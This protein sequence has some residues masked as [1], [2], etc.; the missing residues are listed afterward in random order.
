MGACYEFYLYKIVHLIFSYLKSHKISSPGYT[1]LL[2]K[3]KIITLSWCKKYLKNIK[4]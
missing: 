2:S 3:S 4:T 1:S